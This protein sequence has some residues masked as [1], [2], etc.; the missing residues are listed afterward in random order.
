M[1]I[2]QVSL[3]FHL[4]LYLKHN[5]YTF[6]LSNKINFWMLKNYILYIKS[7]AWYSI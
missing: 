3:E 6:F 4:I 1:R 7:I 2:I 5:Y